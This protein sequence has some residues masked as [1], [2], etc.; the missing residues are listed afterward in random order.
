MERKHKR[1]VNG[2]HI[3]VPTWI[4]SPLRRVNNT[5]HASMAKDLL[6]TSL[7]WVYTVRVQNL[8]SSGWASQNC[9]SQE[10]GNS[11]LITDDEPH[12]EWPI[13]WRCCTEPVRWMRLLGPRFSTVEVRDMA[14][15][16]RQ[17]SNLEIIEQRLGYVEICHF[18]APIIHLNVNIRI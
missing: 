15:V 17:V 9:C 12:Y 6:G 16:E 7:W 5:L 13:P 3:C 11:K 4:I 1:N 18:R 2:R 10:D 14:R 8:H